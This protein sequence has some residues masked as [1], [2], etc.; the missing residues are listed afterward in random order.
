MEK[1]YRLTRLAHHSQI[2]KLLAISLNT[3]GSCSSGDATYL[4]DGHYRRL[5]KEMNP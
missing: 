1:A 3:V 2:E 5:H 4:C